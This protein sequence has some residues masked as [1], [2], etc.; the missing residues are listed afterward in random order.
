MI[1]FFSNFREFDR[2][3]WRLFFLFCFDQLERDRVWTFPI[4]KNEITWSL[5]RVRS[6]RQ[7]AWK[8]GPSRVI[9]WPKRRSKT[10][11]FWSDDHL[12]GFA[13]LG[14]HLGN[15]DPRKRSCDQ[16]FSVLLT[17]WLKVVFRPGP[18][19]NL[20]FSVI[21]IFEKKNDIKIVFT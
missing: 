14:K 6:F 18:S 3:V 8:C 10:E 13:V 5:A 17:F 15:A 12:R 1:G 16:N 9:M 4:G 21:T 20:L 11:N 7:K 2:N 19:R